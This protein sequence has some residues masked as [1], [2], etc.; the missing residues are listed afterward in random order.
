MTTASS[1]VDE[2][3]GQFL[4][5]PLCSEL[6][7]HPKVLTCLHTFCCECLENYYEMEEQERPYRFL[8]YNRAISCPICRQKSELPTGGIGRFPENFLVENLSNVIKKRMPSNEKK[9]EIFCEICRET[10]ESGKQRVAVTRCLDCV[11]HLCEFCSDLHKKTKV[12]QFHALFDMQIEKSVQCRTH[13]DEIVKY[14]C[15]PCDECVCILCAFH[16]HK[17]HEVSTIAEVL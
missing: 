4:V 8:L 10:D 5:C 13:S 7:K 14:F 17:N 12:T 15:E 16:Q 11:K 2:V 9:E 1:F 3:Y 6:Y